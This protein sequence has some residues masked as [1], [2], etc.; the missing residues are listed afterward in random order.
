MWWGG[1]PEQG[2]LD[3]FQCFPFDPYGALFLLIEN[4]GNVAF[5]VVIVPEPKMREK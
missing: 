4:G 2:V 5:G 1:E 3:V